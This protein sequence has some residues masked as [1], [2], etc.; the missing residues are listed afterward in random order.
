MFTDQQEDLKDNKMSKFQQKVLSCVE[1]MLA[2]NL[3]IAIS[4][5]IDVIT[6]DEELLE[7]YPFVGYGACFNWKDSFDG[8][9][10]WFKSEI[11]DRNIR[12]PFDLLSICIMILF[13]E[14]RKTSL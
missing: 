3:H 5:L 4:T 10:Q 6:E 7:S 9:A 14:K 12:N 1:N 13:Q 11:K 2:G 8:P